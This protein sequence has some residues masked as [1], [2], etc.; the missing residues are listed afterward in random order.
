MPMLLVKGV[1]EE[2]M[3][4][5][6]RCLEN[7][8][9]EDTRHKGRGNEHSRRDNLD[10]VSKL[11]VKDG[12]WEEGVRLGLSWRKMEPERCLK[13]G[14]VV[15][16]LNL[17]TMSIYRQPPSPETKKRKKPVWV[18]ACKACFGNLQ[19]HAADTASDPN[20]GYPLILTP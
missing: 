10:G 13:T 3:R 14:L 18:L 9:I 7:L 1:V 20:I 11:L 2:R 5:K 8:Q 12:V 6:G 15:K 19:V 4:K 16:R 17:H